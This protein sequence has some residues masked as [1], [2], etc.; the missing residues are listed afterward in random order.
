M[1]TDSRKA[2]PRIRRRKEL[3]FFHKNNKNFTGFL[4]KET[5]DF[6]TI[7]LTSDVAGL[8]AIW[9]AGETVVWSKELTS[10]IDK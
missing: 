9:Y 1:K 7:E 10:I 3:R 2:R 4:I 6:Y 5:H 8:N